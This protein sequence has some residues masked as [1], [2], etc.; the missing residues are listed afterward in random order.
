MIVKRFVAI[1][2]IGSNIHTLYNVT[3]NAEK[4][5]FHR[6]F[7]NIDFVAWSFIQKSLSLFGF[8]ENIKRL[9]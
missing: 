3:Y 7:F 2:Y 8:G 4:Y 1:R 5:N 6:M 9:I